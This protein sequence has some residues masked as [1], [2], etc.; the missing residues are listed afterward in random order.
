[1][2]GLVSGQWRRVNPDVGPDP[3]APARASGVSHGLARVTVERRGHLLSG[4]TGRKGATPS[5]GMYGELGQALGDLQ[6]RTAALRPVV[7]TEAS[8]AAS[9][10][11]SGFFRDRRMP[12]RCPTGA[13]SFGARGRLRKT[14]GNRVAGGCLTIGIRC[15]AADVRVAADNTRFAQIEI[16]W[17]LSHRRSQY[18]CDAGGGWGNAMRD[19]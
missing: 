17:H 11:R 10:C 16:K 8:P 2:E 5:V 7:R 3:L 14:A 18:G 19:C 15:C 12:R 6:P 1:M 13:G 9:D 4:S